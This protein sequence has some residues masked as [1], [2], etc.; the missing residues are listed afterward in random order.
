MDFETFWPRKGGGGG[1][2]GAFS[3]MEEVAVKRHDNM[4]KATPLQGRIIFQ[5]LGKTC[6]RQG[7][8]LKC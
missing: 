3:Q 5:K 2:G 1:G 6:V 8:T 4:S 7:L